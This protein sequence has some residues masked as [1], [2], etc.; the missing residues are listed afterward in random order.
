MI[1]VGVTAIGVGI[2]TQRQ[3]RLLRF[4]VKSEEDLKAKWKE[5][6]VSGDNKLDIKELAA[7]VHGSGI[8][9]SRNEAAAT[10]MALDRNFDDKIAFE[11]FY[12]WWMNAGPTSDRGLSV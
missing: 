12:M 11:E 2:S 5:Y 4:S 1:L 8:D 9:M 6:D 3:L 7:F 10:F